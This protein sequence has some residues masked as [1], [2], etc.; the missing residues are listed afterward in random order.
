MSL[1]EPEIMKNR[2]MMDDSSCQALL[3]GSKTKWTTEI[4][5]EE[6]SSSRK[7]VGVRSGK[8]IAPDIG[9]YVK[10]SYLRVSERL[11]KEEG[12]D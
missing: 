2:H 7:A 11:T 4:A 6:T 1:P 8:T 9:K 12:G 5:K 3:G 10:R